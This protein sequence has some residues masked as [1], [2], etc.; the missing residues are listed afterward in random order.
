MLMEFLD[1]N[2]IKYMKPVIT[3]IYNNNIKNKL[4]LTIYKPL[5][6]LK[7]LGLLSQFQK[8]PSDILYHQL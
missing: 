5:R 6:L 3:I 2:I 1:K 8:L 7:P 4:V